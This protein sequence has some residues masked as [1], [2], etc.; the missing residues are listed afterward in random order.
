M[1]VTGP[2]PGKSLPHPQQM[3]QTA[4][5]PVFWPEFPRDADVREP[6]GR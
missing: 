1:V 2:R 4:R 3:W 5:V 6:E